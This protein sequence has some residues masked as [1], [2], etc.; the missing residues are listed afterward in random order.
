M[1]RIKHETGLSRKFQERSRQLSQKLKAEVQGPS[2]KGSV[3]RLE[4]DILKGQQ[5]SNLG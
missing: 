4:N 1:A 2:L 5:I 3:L